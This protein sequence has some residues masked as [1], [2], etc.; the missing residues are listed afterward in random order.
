MS[1]IGVVPP[2]KSKLP[3]EERQSPE[4]DGGN[5]SPPRRPRKPR[6]DTELV[7]VEPHKL[8]LEA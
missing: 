6:S 5:R 8:D 4:R 7:P 1:G 3:V 2:A